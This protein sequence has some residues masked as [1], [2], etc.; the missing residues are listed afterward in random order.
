VFQ[1]TEQFPWAFEF[2]GSFLE[3]LAAFATSAE[4]HGTFFGDR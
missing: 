3:H 2:N 1:L 4:R